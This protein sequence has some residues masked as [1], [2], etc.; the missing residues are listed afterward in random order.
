MSIDK[1]GVISHVAFVDAEEGDG[2][3]TV[4]EWA[5]TSGLRPG[6]L[7]S[8][9]FVESQ[10]EALLVTSLGDFVAEAPAHGRSPF[11]YPATVL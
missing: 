10:E 1:E 2:N 9:S 7:T 3:V 11:G 5:V 4:L 8:V 6:D